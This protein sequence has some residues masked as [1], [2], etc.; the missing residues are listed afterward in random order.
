MTLLLALACAGGADTA[1]TSTCADSDVTW[2]SFADGF[3]SNYC[4]SCHSSTTQNRYGAPDG[5]DFDTEAQVRQYEAL[6]RS[7]V[8]ED[9]TMPEIG[10]AHV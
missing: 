6:V 5:L 8:L 3:F 7:S 1:D 4:R 9:G 2:V 10:R